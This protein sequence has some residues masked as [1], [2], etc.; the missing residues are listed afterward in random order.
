M[1]LLPISL[2]LSFPTTTCLA[3][4]EYSLTWVAVIFLKAGLPPVRVFQTF[5][6]LKFNTVVYLI[7]FDALGLIIK[8]RRSETI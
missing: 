2:S 1:R 6:L 5:V 3:A 4:Q 8:R 7:I